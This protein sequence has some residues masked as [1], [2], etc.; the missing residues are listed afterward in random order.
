MNLALRRL[1]LGYNDKITSDA[2]LA[3]MRELAKRDE[4]EEAAAAEAEAAEGQLV[5]GLFDVKV[6]FAIFY[7]LCF[8]IDSKN[9]LL[10][11][12]CN[13]TGAELEMLH[14]EAHGTWDIQL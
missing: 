2:V 5:L 7:S 9:S 13:F 12:N 6:Y 11:L 10:F 3:L 8:A 4:G 14:S 1:D